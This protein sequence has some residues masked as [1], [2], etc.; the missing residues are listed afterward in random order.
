[1]TRH[2]QHE[3]GTELQQYD[4]GDEAT[5]SRNL[6]LGRYDE[7][8]VTTLPWLPLVDRGVKN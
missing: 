3:P 4:D 6:E 2:G 7:D 1:M 5:L 8:D